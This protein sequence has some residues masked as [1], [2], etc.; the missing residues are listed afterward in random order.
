MATPTI[1]AVVEAIAA[2]LVAGGLHATPYAPDQVVPPQAIVMV[3]PITYQAGY[4]ARRPILEVPVVVLVSQ[5]LTRIGQLQL[6]DLADP[7]PTSTATVAGMVA[8]D[9]TLGGVV[10]QCQV[11]RYEPL[12][13]EDVGALG[14]LGGRFTF[15][16]TI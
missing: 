15:R 9:P 16:I 10:G 12:S 11:I 13:Q 8:A 6:A 3:P 2:Q 4:S 1:R 7:N 14:Y 5:Q